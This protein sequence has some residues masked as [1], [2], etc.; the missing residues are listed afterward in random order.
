MRS[1]GLKLRYA[2]KCSNKAHAN[3]QEWWTFKNARMWFFER[4]QNHVQVSESKE[5]LY[6]ILIRVGYLFIGYGSDL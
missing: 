1:G 2:Q 6:L 4:S 5:I 3:G